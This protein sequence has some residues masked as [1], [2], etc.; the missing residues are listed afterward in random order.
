MVE[1]WLDGLT[2]GYRRALGLDAGAPLDRRAGWFVV[3]GLGALFFSFLR[4]ELAPLE[5]RGVIF[6]RTQSP[7]GSTVEYTSEQLRAIEK[8]LRA[9]SGSGGL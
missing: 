7:Q 8:L 3:A 1:R 2:N 6:G 5:D 9:D 4:A